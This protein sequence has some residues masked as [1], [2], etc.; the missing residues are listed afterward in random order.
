MPYIG[1]EVGNRFVASKAASVYSGNGSTTAFT[2][3]HAVGSD[4]DILVSVDGVIQ[5]PSVAYAVSS[6]TTLTFTAAPSSNSGNN[7]FV[8]YLFRTVAT[9]DHPSTSSLQ[10]TDGTFTAGITGT[11][12][13]AAQTNITS[14]G[15]LTSFRSTGIDDNADALAMTIDSDEKV[16]I[17]KTSSNL[18]TAGSEFASDGLVRFTRSN[19]N[20]VVNFNKKDNDGDIVSFRKDDT[21]VGSIGVADSGDR[22]YLAGGGAEGI[23]IDNGSNAF[24]PT[25][26]SG[27]YA[28][29][30][31]SLGRSDARWAG[32]YTSDGLF[33]GGT[34][35]ANQLDDYEEGT[36]TPALNQYAGTPTITAAVYTKVGR[37]VTCSVSIDLDGTSDGSNFQI[38][39]LPFTSGNFSSTAVFGGFVSY[40]NTTFEKPIR[41]LIGSANTLINVYTQSGGAATYNGLGNNKTF[42]LVIIYFTS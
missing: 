42:R 38:T 20:A 15:T 11:L 33:V 26:A 3:E 37:Q 39:G 36:W 17:G 13:T 40:S 27:A 2:L 1:N 8:Y 34:G 5:E 23:G 30:H 18:S 22:I 28:D 21:Q 41:F 7:I 4:E 24:V 10:A 16:L 9:V 14:V 35:S 25:N 19:V 29:N 12:Q 31:I 6:G 32:I